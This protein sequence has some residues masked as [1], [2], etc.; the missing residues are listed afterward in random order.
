MCQTLR[1][2]TVSFVHYN[3]TVSSFKEI[4]VYKIYKSK[5]LG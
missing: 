5:K 3:A 1:G 4:V 2:V